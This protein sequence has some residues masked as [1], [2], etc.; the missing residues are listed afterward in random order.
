MRLLP[1]YKLWPCYGSDNK[2]CGCYKPS[3]R[4][5]T[6]RSARM[7]GMKLPQCTG[8]GL[9]AEAGTA[10]LIKVVDSSV[11]ASSCIAKIVQFP[12]Q[13][14][15]QR[16]AKG[17]VAARAKRVQKDA[18]G[19]VIKGKGAANKHASKG[20]G[21]RFGTGRAGRRYIDV[22]FVKDGASAAAELNDR[23]HS[24]VP[25]QHVDALR[26]KAAK[27]VGLN[28]PQQIPATLADWQ[29]EAGKVVAKLT[30]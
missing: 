6:S 19:A 25:A 12:V 17:R 24:S 22:V 5:P 13:A 18:T 10:E 14:A 28:K 7:A 30:K 1:G 3:V 27:H 29:G 9:A 26:S 21:G 11:H 23:G 8:H 4:M 2:L 20:N 15:Q 16:T